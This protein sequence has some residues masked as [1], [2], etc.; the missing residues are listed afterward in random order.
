LNE[1]GSNLIFPETKNNHMTIIAIFTNSDANNIKLFIENG[2]PGPIIATDFTSE[3]PFQEVPDV[4][5][6]LGG[7]WK[8]IFATHTYSVYE[9][10]PV[11]SWTHPVEELEE[12]I[13]GLIDR[14]NARDPAE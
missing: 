8:K 3:F 11:R 5:R 14:L 6:I 13:K 4:N 12:R 10:L 9:R 2:Y 1:G 7:E